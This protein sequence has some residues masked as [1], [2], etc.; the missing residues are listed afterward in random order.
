[1]NRELKIAA[2]S[3]AMK[4]IN[5]KMVVG[6]GTGSTTEC[7]IKLLSEK[8]AKLD[9]KVV[10]S[11]KKTEML[12]RKLNLNILDLNDVEKVD[13]VIDGVDEIDAKKRMIKGGGAA[14]LREKILAE[15]SDKSLIIADCSKYV[16][17]LGG[18]EL[19]IEVVP[20]G[21][22]HVEKKINELGFKSKLRVDQNNNIVITDN[23]NYIF[24]VLL[25]S[26]GN[27]IS[28]IHN[29]LIS[30]TGVIETGLFINFNPTLIIAHS[31]TDVRIID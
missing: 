25:F 14:L 24:D 13:I 29:K 20:Y 30:I 6:L 15:A 27:D 4:F 21:Y 16:E 22:R 31:L 11:S 23:M 28:D 12:A 1:M 17:Q 5:D 26:T 18:R 3:E 10:V 8:A 2:A 9:I 19:P 7:F